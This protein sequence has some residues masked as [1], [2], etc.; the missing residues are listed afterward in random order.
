MLEISPIIHPDV[1][2][3]IQEENPRILELIEAFGSSLH[4]VF[5]EI[6]GANLTRFQETL[7]ESNVEGS[8]FYAA[9]AN[10]SEAVLEAMA[11]AGGGADVSS[12]YEL[13]QALSHGIRG[14]N[15]AMS[16]PTKDPRFLLLGIQQGS[17]IAIDSIDDLKNIIEILNS[18]DD[19]QKAKITIRLNDVGE[20]K[21]RFGI[22]KSDLPAVYELLQANS[23]KIEFSGFA[24]HLD[25]Y[26]IEERS[27]AILSVVEEIQRARSIGFNCNTVDIGG[28]FTISYVDKNSWEQFQQANKGEEGAKLFFHGKRFKHFYPYYNEK[29]GPAFLKEVLAYEQDGTRKSIA[30]IL[31]ESNIQLV[32]EPGRSILDQAGITLMRVKGIKQTASG[33]HVI[34]AEANLNHLSE[35]WFCTEFIPDPILIQAE[36]DNSS[37]PIEAS[38]AGNTC[39]EMDMITWRKIGFKHTP[40][41]GDVLVYVNTAGY[42][43]DTN[44][45]DF[46]RIPVPQKVA[47]YRKRDQWAWK[48]DS[49]F[50]MLDITT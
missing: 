48:R 15:I 21:S 3:F 28:G 10:K 42:Q 25:G 41:S 44:E 33:N 47:A 14:E 43:M 16:G 36:K 30:E 7:R 13:R 11:K 5:P 24:F 49:E 17:T 32:V 4:I 22:P 46:H 26:S 19:K 12:V 38:V 40:K 20:N 1:N 50:S 39:M 2:Q 45:T 31:I 6:A 18:L 37:E 27:K 8:V 35:Q 34:L 9:K 29:P 23:G